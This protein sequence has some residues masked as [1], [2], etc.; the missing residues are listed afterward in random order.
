MKDFVTVKTEGMTTVF[1][2][3]TLSELNDLGYD[4]VYDLSEDFTA[5]VHDNYPGLVRFAEFD[6]NSRFIAINCDTE[7]IA[8]TINEELQYF[9]AYRATMIAD[10]AEEDERDEIKLRIQILQDEINELKKLLL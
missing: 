6:T 3:P 4:N 7:E 9:M 2:E 10:A 1:F 8:E 5:T